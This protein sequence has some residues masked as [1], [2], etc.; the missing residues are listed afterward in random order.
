MRDIILLPDEYNEFVC[1]D[2]FHIC[3]GHLIRS[4]KGVWNG[5]IVYIEQTDQNRFS[6][7]VDDSILEY[8]K[9]YEYMIAYLKEKT[10]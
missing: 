5:H 9:S 1:D 10:S 6:F 2:R 3:Y 7:W 8:N 4:A